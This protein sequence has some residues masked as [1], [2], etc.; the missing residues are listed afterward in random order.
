MWSC[1]IFLF[2]CSSLSGCSKEVE[3]ERTEEILGTIVSGKVITSQKT[4][5]L[6][7][8]FERAKELELIFSVNDKKS[9]LSKVNETAWKE[10]VEASEELMKKSR[11]Y[12]F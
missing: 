1:F 2:V 9:E 5:P 11:P 3:Q 6:E 8:A 10:P 12:N 7:K 4:E